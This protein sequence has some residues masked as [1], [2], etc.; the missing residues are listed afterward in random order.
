MSKTRFL[1]DVNVLVA[2]AEGEHEHH[3]AAM[4]WFGASEPDWG[5][6]PLTE[7]GFFRVSTRR[8]AG[9]RSVQEAMAVY[10]EMVRFPGYRFWP[11]SDPCLILLK[12]VANR[13]FGPNQVTDALLLG[14]AIKQNGV[15]VT[16]DDGIRFLAGLDY[17][18]NVLV[19]G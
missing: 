11:L 4:R 3:K 8:S 19:L 7:A 10:Q 13:L 12:P 18:A 14:L 17:A 9:G 1:L 5:V 6:C 2:M 16:F 15:L